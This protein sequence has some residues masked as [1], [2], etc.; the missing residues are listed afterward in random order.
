M[1]SGKPET[2][3]GEKSKSNL[4]FKAFYLC[5]HSSTDCNNPLLTC[6]MNPFVDD[7]LENLLTHPG[8][9]SK[10]VCNLLTSREGG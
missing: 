6:D 7:D 4:D 8:K 10:N 1:D 3:V 9:I 5:Q 2:C